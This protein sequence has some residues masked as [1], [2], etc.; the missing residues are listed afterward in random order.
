MAVCL[1]KSSVEYQTLLKRS[2]LSEFKFNAF[3]SMFVGKYG[4]YPELD[5]IPGADS[6]PY[7]NKALSV[8]TIDDTNFVKNDKILSQTGSSDVKEANVKINNSYRD[9]EVKLTPSNDTVS[10]IQIRKRPNRWDN[11]YKGGVLID[12]GVTP[13]RNL[14]VFN[15]ILEKLA[16]LYGINFIGITNAELAS[17][18]WKGLVDDAKTTNAFIYNGDIYINLDNSSIEAPLHEMLHLFLGSVRYSDPQLYFSLA[19][20]MNKL[21]NRDVLASY[22]RNRTNS[23]INEELLVSEFSKYLTGQKSAVENLPEPVLQKVLY[24]MNRVLDSVLF[25]QQS[26]TTFSTMELFDKSLLKLSEYLGS[27]LAN[28]QYS[29]TLNV[30]S[31]EVHRILANV[32]SDLMKSND[33]KEFCG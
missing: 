31:A 20:L 30:K 8:K 24:N 33:L 25:G 10:T 11:I 5:E 18:E 29:G 32:K 14:C 2:G 1:N 19:E 12:D 28:N 23:D 15:N 26:V 9:L 22:Y 6:R 21:P 3:A 13:T 27:T 16:N 7:L 17:D 4:R